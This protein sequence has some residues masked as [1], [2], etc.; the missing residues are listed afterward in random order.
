MKL[1]WKKLMIGSMSA[2][3]ALSTFATAAPAVKAQDKFIISAAALAP[4]LK[5][6]IEE[7]AKANNVEVEVLDADMFAQLDA[8]ALD[9][10]AGNGAD[11]YIAAN[12]RV[13]S[14]GKAEHLAPVTLLEDA[15]YDDK[16]KQAVSVDGTIYGAPAVIETIVMYYNKDLV[17]EAPK[18]LDEL[19]ELSKDDKYKFEGEEGKNTAFLAQ[20]TNFYFGYGVVS[21]YGGYVFGQDGTDTSDLGLNNDGAV[22]GINY[23]SDWYK[24]VWPQGMLDVKS[25]GDFMKQS[26]IDGKTAAI[27]SGPWEYASLMEANVN[28][29]VA[30]LPTLPNGKEYQ[31]FGGG[32]SWVISAYSEKQELAQKFLDWVSSEEQQMKLYEK[33]GEVPAN[34]VAREKAAA[35]DSELTKAVIDSFA[36]ATPMPNIPEMG[37]VWPGAENL[38]FDA[39]SGA[40]TA[41][42]AADAA[43]ELIKQGISQKHN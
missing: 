5:D 8:L 41:K 1:N 7:F 11:V 10:P 33:Q 21:G 29:G 39:A 2:A 24:N 32:K 40:K 37:E 27:I 35:G 12:D 30:K 4:Y 13:G 18:T 31:P 9:G 26:F 19:M 14:L 23:I 3:M 43:V 42:E 20:W 34:H 6:N 16:D 15:K 25:S 28:L 22:E 17:K 38:I 36:N